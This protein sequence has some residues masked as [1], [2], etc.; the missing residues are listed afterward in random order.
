MSRERFDHLLGL[1]E[2]NITKEDTN[3]R[4]AISVGE[5]LL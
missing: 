5:G 2:N 4:K 3:L 1:V